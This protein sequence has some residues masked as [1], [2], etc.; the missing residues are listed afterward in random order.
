MGKRASAEG[1]PIV[2]LLR[3]K[4]YAMRRGGTDSLAG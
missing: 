4:K 1:A 3:Q 2:W